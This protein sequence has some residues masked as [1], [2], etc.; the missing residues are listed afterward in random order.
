MLEHP[1]ENCFY[2]FIMLNYYLNIF[3]HLSEMWAKHFDLK[4]YAEISFVDKI[5]LLICKYISSQ[6]QH[7]VFEMDDFN[8]IMKKF[9]ENVTKMK[10]LKFRSHLVTYY[11]L[12]IRIVNNKYIDAK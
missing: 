6:N 10:M 1:I 5:Q 2:A 9:Q 8:W 12:C 11:L 4:V 7:F 3:G